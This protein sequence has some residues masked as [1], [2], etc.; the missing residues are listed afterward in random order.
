MPPNWKVFNLETTEDLEKA[1]AYAKDKPSLKK[2]VDQILTVE[3][4]RL[5]ALDPDD[6]IGMN[7]TRSNNMF[8]NLTIEE[9]KDKLVTSTRNSLPWIGMPEA[10]IVDYPN[11]KAV[12]I[13]GL[14]PQQ[15]GEDQLVEQYSFP[16]KNYVF[17]VSFLCVKSKQDKL[18]E[19]DRTITSNFDYDK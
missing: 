1:K 14:F 16:S 19:F 4:A 15:I 5:V 2:L 8:H 17:T 11:G 7:V 13:K 3:Q 18:S 12:L 6:N 10:G 9:L